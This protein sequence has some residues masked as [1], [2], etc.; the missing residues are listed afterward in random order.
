LLTTKQNI[1]SDMIQ[2]CLEEIHLQVF[3]GFAWKSTATYDKL[4]RQIHVS[5]HL[6]CWEESPSYGND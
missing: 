2:C 3:P 4:F 1:F 6:S 5:I